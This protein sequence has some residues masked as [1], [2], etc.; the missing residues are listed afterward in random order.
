MSSVEPYAQALP[1]SRGWIQTL[2]LSSDLVVTL[3][4]IGL[5][6]GNV[7]VLGFPSL[8]PPPYIRLTHFE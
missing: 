8:D 7:E 2:V 5:V 1:I 4:L 6:V 3:E